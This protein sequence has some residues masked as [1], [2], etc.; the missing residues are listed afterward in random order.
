M[1]LC[2]AELEDERMN[3]QLVAPLVLEEVRVQVTSVVNQVIVGHYRASL[4]IEVSVQAL[5]VAYDQALAR[6]IRGRRLVRKV[7]LIVVS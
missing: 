6:S 3:H 7:L 2:G 1:A 5:P 4:L